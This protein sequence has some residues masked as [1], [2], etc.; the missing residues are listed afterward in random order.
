MSLT[1]PPTTCRSMPVSLAIHGNQVA[2]YTSTGMATRPPSEGRTSFAIAPSH[3]ASTPASR[4][5]RALQTTVSSPN[6]AMYQM[7][8]HLMPHAAPRHTPAPKRHQRKP[9]HGPY[10]EL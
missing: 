2:T 6:A 8:D 5:A 9:S 3:G 1:L 7:P 10:G 4:R